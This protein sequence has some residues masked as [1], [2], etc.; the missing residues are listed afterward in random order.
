L[1][2]SF[3]VNH[4]CFKIYWQKAK[5]SCADGRKSKEVHVKASSILSLF[6]LVLFM[7]VSVSFADEQ[8]AADAPQSQP[9]MSPE[10]QKMMEEWTKAMT[11]GPQHKEL[12]DMAGSWEFK[13]TFWMSPGAPPQQSSGTVERTM[14]MG[15]RILQEKVASS[16]MGQPFE[17]LG[18]TGYD[19]VSGEYWSTWADS[20]GTGIMLATGKCKDTKCEFTGTYNDPMVGGKKTVRMTLA[21]EPDRE[22][23]EMFDRTPDGKEFKSGEMV[24]TRKK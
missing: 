7:A 5:P 16:W 17:G 8:K 14:I 24:Y 3:S 11:P 18:L 10:E 19:N 12:A 21:S 20:M 6:T 1:G 4:L 9:K 15:G 23:H 13:G 2:T 22:I